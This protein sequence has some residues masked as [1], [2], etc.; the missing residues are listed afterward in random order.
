[1]ING[2]NKEDHNP[3][4]GYLYGQSVRGADA[5]FKDW[6]TSGGYRIRELLDDDGNPVKFIHKSRIQ[7]KELH[8]NV[9]KPGS[10][11]PSK[12][13]S[14]LIRSR[15]LITPKSMPKSRKRTGK[16]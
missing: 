9:L 1:M 10:K 3:R 13:R 5:E 7:V 2:D 11:K 8:I 14:V 4:D 15:W 12:R 6:V 16:P